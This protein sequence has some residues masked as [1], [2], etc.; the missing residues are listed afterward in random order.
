MIVMVDD[1]GIEHSVKALLDSGSECCFATEELANRMEI[2]RCNAN[3][4]IEGI[5]QASTEVLY[6]FRSTVKSRI[7]SY[8]TE[9]EAF[10]LPKV[11]VD[12]PTM[13]VDV[14]SWSI[15]TGI[16]LADPRFYQTSP[17]DVVLGAEVFFNLFNT[18]G[19]IS[20]G[21]SLPSLVNS[22]LGWI[23]SGKVVQE[24]VATPAV[25]SL[26]SIIEGVGSSKL[27]TLQSWQQRKF[28]VRHN[29][30]SNCNYHNFDNSIPTQHRKNGRSKYNHR[31]RIFV[32]QSKDF[33]IRHVLN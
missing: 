33:A 27:T 2:R 15:P 16:H 12:L 10:I 28:H 11:T 14:S 13:P 1:N 6:K 9:I 23:V 5:G 8:A 7:T 4:P 31:S 26:A 25:C 30:Q 17:I 18:G 24:R 3:V 21:E 29:M 19:H 20:L 32:R 22:T